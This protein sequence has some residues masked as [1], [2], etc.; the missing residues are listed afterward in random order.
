MLKLDDLSMSRV[1]KD[2]GLES[3][4]KGV[5]RARRLSLQ[6]V[7]ESLLQLLAKVDAPQVMPFSNTLILA[8]EGDAAARRE[9]ELLGEW[10]VWRRSWETSGAAWLLL[11]D[12]FVEIEMASQG[13]DTC[14]AEFRWHDAAELARASPL[15]NLYV[16]EVVV[17]ILAA[18]STMQ[19]ALLARTVGLLEVLL[20]QLARLDVWMHPQQLPQ[21]SFRLLLGMKSDMLR[22]PGGA[23]VHWLRQQVGAKTLAEL[24]S[25]DGQRDLVSESTLKRW[26]SGA[27]FPSEDQ[28][29]SVVESCL[30]PQ[31]DAA[32]SALHHRA[33]VMFFVARRLDKTLRLAE[34]LFSASSGTSTSWG[35]DLL[36]VPS[37]S[38][39]ASSRYDWWLDH[40]TSHGVG[41]ARI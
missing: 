13:V 11:I 29:R 15:L 7:P 2:M 38:E 25:N 10:Q 28:F 35:A 40:W 27:F 19:E 17:D 8:I 37:A 16:N 34:R 32:R 9:V 4:F 21:D 30:S 39:W 6:A 18:A 31:E 20:A 12:H 41:P 23:L 26:S 14:I 33:R 24:L 22:R 5:E 3:L 1:F 36:G